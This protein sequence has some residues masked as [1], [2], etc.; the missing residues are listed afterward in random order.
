M[1]YSQ[2][3]ALES[4]GFM[5]EWFDQQAD[6]M[7]EYNLTVFKPQR[8]PLEAALYDEKAKRAFLKRMPIP[9][10]NLEDLVVGSTITIHARHL[11]V[12][13]YNDAHT[14]GALESGR[15]EFAIL[16]Q[17]VAFRQFG[18]II[19][20]IEMGKLTISR[21]RL[22]NQ[23]GPVVAIQV[24]GTDAASVWEE[25][26]MNIPKEA[27]KKV[28]PEV[29]APYFEDKVTYPCTAAFDHCTLCIIRPH[30]VK[31]RQAGQAIEAIQNA[32]FEIS[33]LQML[34]MQ[35]A[36]AAEM[37]DV[38]KGVVPYHKEMVDG[39]SIAPLIALE[40]RGPDQV[41]EKLRQLCGPYD[42][43]M[44]RHLR[45]DSLRARFGVDNANNGVH[46]TDLEDDAEFEVR[47]V[48]EMLAA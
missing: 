1:A 47:Y 2:A 19:T 37:L 31:A 30:L 38:Y 28:T 5:V 23:G 9:D 13:S 43:D 7:R 46:A 44:A 11:K 16:V 39:M 34:H 29:A 48:F 27:Y 4:F 36:E 40:I 26:S 12:K 41:V 20:C 3:E 18:Q 35:K 32:G 8:G 10:L 14:R 22:I 6:L 33:A 45:P 42:V 17:P 21:M 24:V 15:G 25:V